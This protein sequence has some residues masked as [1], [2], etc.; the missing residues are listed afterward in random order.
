MHEG[1]DVKRETSEIPPSKRSTGTMHIVPVAG[2]VRF[3][4]SACGYGTR[5]SRE[6]DA[7]LQRDV[8][9]VA[10][11]LGRLGDGPG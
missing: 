5:A 3:R 1:A 6:Q 2:P 7:S 11:Q 9:V 8:G 10:L 4:V